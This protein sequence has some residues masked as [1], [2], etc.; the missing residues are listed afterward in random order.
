MSDAVRRSAYS[1]AVEAS[2]RID[3]PS[4]SLNQRKS[5]DTALE[6]IY[7][8]CTDS[9]IALASCEIR[10]ELSRTTPGG[11]DEPEWILRSA[12]ALN[13]KAYCLMNLGRFSEALSIYNEII[14]KFGSSQ[15]SAL[16]ERVAKALFNKAF[17]H[18]AF[19]TLRRGSLNL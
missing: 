7:I 1:E 12:K 9:Q 8:G 16:R 2:R 10:L 4:L 5:L 3:L 11:D 15:D 6:G 17:A 13:G 18:R 14:Q 19:G